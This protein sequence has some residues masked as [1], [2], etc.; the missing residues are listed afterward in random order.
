MEQGFTGAGSANGVSGQNVI[1]PD[2]NGSHALAGYD[3]AS[4]GP[5]AGFDKVDDVAGQIGA[6]GVGHGHF[7]DEAS[8]AGGA[9]PGPWKQT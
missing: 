7:S 1:R 6:D 4:G 5:V 8:G 2:E 3:A 9:A